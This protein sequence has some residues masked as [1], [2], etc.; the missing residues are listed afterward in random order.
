M[1]TT[2][3]AMATGVVVGL[4]IS[5]FLLRY[6]NKNGVMKTEYDEMQQKARGKAYK[7]A[8]YAMMIFE[9]ILGILASGEVV[10]PFNNWT[11]HFMPI[12]VGLV[13]QISYCIWNDAYIGLNTNTGRFAAISVVIALVNIL[14]AGLEA[15][16]GNLI[17]DGIFQ[18]SF[19][20]L[21]IGIL[22][23]VIGCELLLKKIVDNGAKE[24]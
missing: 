15:S 4:V 20:N 6:M 14:V 3:I 2:M 5:A 9:A 13:V 21:I 12:F 17:V 23:G 11:L 22:F 19:T 18:A 1:N 10:L 24:D 8:F 7:Y 16:K